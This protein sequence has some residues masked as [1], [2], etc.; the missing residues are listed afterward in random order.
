MTET[1]STTSCKGQDKLLMWNYSLQENEIVEQTE[2][3]F[4]K[5]T[6]ICYNSQS[7]GFRVLPQYM[8]RVEWKGPTGIL[9]KKVSSIDTGE[10]TLY[11]NL[12]MEQ[13][14]NTQTIFLTVYE[15]PTYTCKPSITIHSKDV[16]FCS[17]KSCGIPLLSHEWKLLEKKDPVGNESYLK[18]NS[19]WNAEIVFCCLY[20]PN[21]HC[22]DGDPFEFCISALIS[23]AEER[24]IEGITDK[25]APNYRDRENKSSVNHRLL[26][27]VSVLLVT[28]ILMILIAVICWQ[29]RNIKLCVVKHWNTNRDETHAKELQVFQSIPMLT[30]QNTP[31]EKL[32][33]RIQIV[34]NVN[35]DSEVLK[36]LSSFQDLREQVQMLEK[37]NKKVERQLYNYQNSLQFQERQKDPAH[38]LTTMNFAEIIDYDTDR[39]HAESEY[40]DARSEN[41]KL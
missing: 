25:I 4:N 13:T 21:M 28:M 16:F 40:E 10:Y 32:T 18:I 14:E 26:T 20:G 35:F 12:F 6:A 22:H 30:D 19:S 2:W 11:P 33:Q 17:T 29:R 9:L 41:S 39:S 38:E 27:V 7:R 31:E 24:P 1:L 37:E 15:P 36:S 34:N 3:F 8:G 5:T 23:S